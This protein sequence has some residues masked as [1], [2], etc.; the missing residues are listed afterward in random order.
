MVL[1]LM[2]VCCK[3]RRPLLVMKHYPITTLFL[4]TLALTQ[5][6]AAEK[7]YGPGLSEAEIKIGEVV[8]K[9]PRRLRR[10]SVRRAGPF[11]SVVNEKG[12]AYLPPKALEAARHRSRRIASSPCSAV[13]ATPVNVALQRYLTDAKVPVRLPLETLYAG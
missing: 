2:N 9:W 4:G 6:V 3:L 1:V 12:G 5:A 10:D 11:F 7:H 13:S 8:P